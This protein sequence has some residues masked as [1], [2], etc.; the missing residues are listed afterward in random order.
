MTNTTISDSTAWNTVREES[1]YSLVKILGI[2]VVNGPTGLV[3]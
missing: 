1:Q 2:W 3:A